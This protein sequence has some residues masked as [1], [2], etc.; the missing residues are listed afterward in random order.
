MEIV[1]LEKSMS[2]LRFAPASVARNRQRSGKYGL[3]VWYYLRP[4]KGRDTG[5]DAG[6]QDYSPPQPGPISTTLKNRRKDNERLRTAGVLT[7]LT[8]WMGGD[9]QMQDL[10]DAMSAT[11]ANMV[12]W[13]GWAYENL[14]NGTSGQPYPELAK[15]YSRAYPAAVAG[16]PKS[17]SFS[18]RSATFKLQFTSDPNIDAPTEI[19][20]PPS[21]FPNG[22]RVQ[23]SPDGSLLQYSL[24]KR[25]LALFTSTSVKNA[26]DISVIISP[27]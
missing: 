17:F 24:D 18:E 25:T 20:L 19:I 9:K 16:T 6:Q 15:H 23:V 5:R 22:Y 7:E 14:Y 13:I 4:R 12:S 11:D 10:A 8:F 26:T 21:T 1:E 27:K 2:A 3:H